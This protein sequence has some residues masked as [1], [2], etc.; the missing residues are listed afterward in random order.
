MPKCVGAFEDKATC[1]N[2]IAPLAI[3]FQGVHFPVSLYQMKT[4]PA[5]LAD[6]GSGLY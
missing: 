5:G 4:D 2:L 6:P 3:E 1:F